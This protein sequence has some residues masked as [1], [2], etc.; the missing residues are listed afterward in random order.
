ML[1][2]S[3]LLVA[4]PAYVVGILRGV[5]GRPS[6]RRTVESRRGPRLTIAARVRGISNH[7]EF[8][9]WANPLVGIEPEPFVTLV[10]VRR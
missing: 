8:F 3:F 6:S 10:V 9:L 1:G 7:H 5:E 2:P 4:K